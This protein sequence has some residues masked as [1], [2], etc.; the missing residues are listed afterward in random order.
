MVKNKMINKRK[1]AAIFVAKVAGH[2]DHK[3]VQLLTVKYKE[4]DVTDDKAKDNY[5]WGNLMTEI[6]DATMNPLLKSMA[7]HIMENASKALSLDQWQEIVGDREVWDDRKGGQL[8]FS[9]DENSTVNFDRGALNV[10][11][12]ANSYNMDRLKQLLT[13]LKD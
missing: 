2:P 11:R 1:L 8:L 10:E 3:T 5:L 13:G 12:G 6:G 4:G 9:D 7:D